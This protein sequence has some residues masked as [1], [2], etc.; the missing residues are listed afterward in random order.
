MGAWCKSIEALVKKDSKKAKESYKK[1]FKYVKTHMLKED[2]VQTHMLEKPDGWVLHPIT[3][4]VNK[5]I[6][7]EKEN[8]LVNH[9]AQMVYRL[10]QTTKQY[11]QEYERFYEKH[12]KMLADYDGVGPHRER[13]PARSSSENERIS[14]WNGVGAPRRR[15]ADKQCI[16]SENDYTL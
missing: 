13:P 6:D 3:V 8:K 10:I 15:C 7:F 9:M 16:N 5:C 14:E 4:L 12:K 2:L 11:T 1:C